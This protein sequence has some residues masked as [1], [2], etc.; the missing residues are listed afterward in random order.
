MEKRVAVFWKFVVIIVLTL[1]MQI[2]IHFIQG[3]ANNKAT[4]YSGLSYKANQTINQITTQASSFLSSE[5][6]KNDIID[7]EQNY[8]FN[9]QILHY[10]A[11]FMALAY[12]V[13]LVFDMLSAGRIHLVQY[14]VVGVGLLIFYL[15][16]MVLSG[17]M[18]FTVAYF[19]SAAICSLLLLFYLSVSFK[20]VAF[21]FA[22][23]ICLML[24]Y[25][26]TFYIATL[27]HSL[28]LFSVVG[29]V[30]LFMVFISFTRKTD[31]N[32]RAKVTKGG[33]S[34]LN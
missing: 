3:Y 12:L 15:L 5:E 33:A 18:N 25:T 9:V 31:W 11:L 22:F 30:L 8:S 19:I 16:S 24:L 32:A 17:Y 28:L 4:E 27:T 26:G 13:L 20:H 6:V 14:F 2:P 21:S 29:I 34:K 10:S 7:K 23:A 1:F